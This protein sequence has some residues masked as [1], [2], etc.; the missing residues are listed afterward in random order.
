MSM[1]G[2]S[3]EHG[4]AQKLMMMENAAARIASVKAHL[5]SNADQVKKEI[6]DV[7]SQQLSLI[8]AREQELL[9]ELDAVFSYKE[10]TLSR[11]QQ[12]LHQKI[13]SCQQALE[14]VRKG[15][16]PANAVDVLLR[17]SHIDMSPREN[18]RL[19]F[20][21][22]SIELRATLATFGIIHTIF[23][24]GSGPM[25]DES[26]PGESLPLEM[27]DYDDDFAMAHKSVMRL[28]NAP[29]KGASE[30]AESVRIYNFSL[31]TFLFYGSSSFDLNFI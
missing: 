11:Q 17:I 25:V 24:Q 2:R 29:V 22:D 1:Q 20:E 14:S 21:S 12:Q 26:R 5:K 6:G 31:M 15:D 3:L 23:E 13:G 7:I 9:S 30:Q 16:R 28:S 18:S 27:E 10:N 19:A 8:R 4:L